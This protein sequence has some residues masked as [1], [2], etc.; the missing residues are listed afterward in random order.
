MG[1]IIR[2]FY[3]EDPD[4]G[5]GDAGTEGFYLLDKTFPVKR[6]GYGEARPADDYFY[7]TV[8]PYDMTYGLEILSKGQLKTE[9]HRL[10]SQI[11]KLLEKRNQAH[12]ILSRIKE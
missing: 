3:W 9:Y 8:A 12:D 4:K 1:T 5:W 6:Y 2:R 10:L 7:S 11:N